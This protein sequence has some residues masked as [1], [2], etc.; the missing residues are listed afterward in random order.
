[1]RIQGKF[2]ILVSLLLQ[3]FIN[4]ARQQTD[5]VEFKDARYCDWSRLFTSRRPGSRRFDT[6]RFSALP[7]EEQDLNDDNYQVTFSDNVSRISLDIKHP[8]MCRNTL[9]FALP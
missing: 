4:F 6:V 3:V 8:K 2:V 1:M 7:E 9:V 5:E